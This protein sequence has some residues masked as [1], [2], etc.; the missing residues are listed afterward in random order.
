MIHVNVF[1][2]MSVLA[3]V[4][5]LPAC[6]SSI[7]VYAFTAAGQ[8]SCATFAPTAQV[9]KTIGSGSIEVSTP[10]SGCNVTQNLTDLTG[11]TGLF[12]AQSSA[13]GGGNTAFGVFS[14]DGTSRSQG[15]YNTLGVEAR[16][17]LSG[18]TDAFATRGS[19]AFANMIDGYTTPST[20]GSNG[21][22]QFNYRMHGAQTLSGRGETT[23]ELLWAKNGGPGFLAFRA[24]N[25][26]GTGPTV[27]INGTYVATL[28][29]MV[30]TTD[31]ITMDTDLSFRVAASANEHFDLNMVFYASAIPGP[32]TGLP[33]PSS[34]ADD[35]F[36]TLT[37]TGIDVLDSQGTVVSGA[38]VLRDSAAA[39]AE[40]PEPG[41]MLLVGAALAML[42]LIRKPRS[43]QAGI[44]QNKTVFSCPSSRKP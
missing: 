13:T 37:L 35:F 7:E 2:T 40:T 38:Q 21:F 19:E 16:G 18:A 26:S 31:S 23:V 27:N 33:S 4:G 11:A 8:S 5:V 9:S 17:S 39:V 14:Y 12:N 44:T 3:L 43:G 28:P 6:A 20:I 34:I 15:D 22:V 32:S 10:G 36:G 24:Q 1:G 25:G 29:G 42:A 41:S 30:I